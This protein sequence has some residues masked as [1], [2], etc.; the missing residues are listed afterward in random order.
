MLDFKV[1]CQLKIG[2]DT[3]ETTLIFLNMFLLE[4]SMMKFETVDIVIF[5]YMF[6]CT[7]KF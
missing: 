6:N 1:Y 2:E 5:N 4:V 3:S 7:K